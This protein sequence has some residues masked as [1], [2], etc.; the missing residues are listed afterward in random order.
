MTNN[1]YLLMQAWLNSI[2]KLFTSWYIPGTN[3]T[4]GQWLFFLLML[5]LIVKLVKGVLTL[6]L[7]EIFS[8]RGEPSNSG[9]VNDGD[10]YH[11]TWIG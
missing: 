8:D 3:F 2:W 7:A 10:N 5:P 6:G 9:V 1:A 11:V 4:P